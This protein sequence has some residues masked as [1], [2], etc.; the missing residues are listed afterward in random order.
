MSQADAQL[1]LYHEVSSFFRLDATTFNQDQ[2]NQ[3]ALKFD[4]LWRIWG[5]PCLSK[6]STLYIVYGIVIIISNLYSVNDLQIKFNI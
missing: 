3:K 6:C 1:S 2:A 4:I 5:I